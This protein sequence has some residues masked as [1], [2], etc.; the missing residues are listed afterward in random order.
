MCVCGV[1]YLCLSFCL[2]LMCKNDRHRVQK[3]TLQ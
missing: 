2:S 3:F 1:L